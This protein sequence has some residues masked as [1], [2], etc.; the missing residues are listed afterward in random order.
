VNHHHLGLIT[1]AEAIALSDTVWH[2]PIGKIGVIVLR[3]TALSRVPLDLWNAN[4]EWWQ[5]LQFP[6]LASSSRVPK[7]SRP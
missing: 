7:I 5:R 1:A 2:K 6:A 4:G 3:L